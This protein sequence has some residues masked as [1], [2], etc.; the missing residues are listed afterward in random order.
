M[1]KIILAVTLL[2]G[3][4]SCKNEHHY[5]HGKL[6]IV[7]KSFNGEANLAYYMAKDSTG[8]EFDFSNKYSVG[9]TLK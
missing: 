6:I 5:P 9:D 7:D 4:T 2:C 8:Q 1:N 3:A